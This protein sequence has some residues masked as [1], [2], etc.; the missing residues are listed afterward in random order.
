MRRQGEAPM[1]P[2]AGSA[3][4]PPHQL[5]RL[6]ST[7]PGLTD[8]ADALEHFFGT[9]LLFGSLAGQA[10][11]ARR[12]VSL[13]ERLATLPRTNL[14]VERP[15]TIR[16]NHHHVPFIEAETD[17]DLAV[18]LG[19][20]HAHL[21]LG[22]LE[23]MRRLGQG[24]VAA[25]IGAGGVAIDHLLRTLDI[26]R[27]VPAII[28]DMP[29]AT[30]AWVEAFLRGLN[31]H[32]M[33]VRPLPPEFDVLKLEPEPWNI[34]DVVTL[35]RLVS[36]DVNWII[37][38]QLLKF[39]NDA[40]WPQLWRKLL[41][42][43]SLSC[44]TS[45]TKNAA[46]DLPGVAFHP[47]SNSFVVGPSRTATGGALIA[48][49]PHLSMILPNAWLLAA[50]KS[51]SYHAA[52][53]MIPG[54]PF[55]ALGRNPWIA[56]GG[57]NLHAASSDFV[58]VP[59]EA[60]S[61]AT[62]RESALRV[63]W[64]H[65]RKIRIRETQWGPVIT[66]APRLSA[67]NRAL[68]LRW[69]GHRPSDEITAMLA[70]NRAR[71]WAE[72]RA[73]LDG[74]AVPGQNMTFAAA[75]GRIGRVMAARLPRRDAG[76]SDDIAVAPGR[77]D[78]WDAPMSSGALPQIADPPE[79]IITSANERPPQ[80]SPSVG[81][82]FAPRDR[83]QR[84]DQ[85]LAAADRLSV[86]AAAQIQRD[87]HWQSALAQC[88]QI[89]TWLDSAGVSHGKSQYH[90]V[91]DALTRWD[92]CYDEASSG[93]LVFEILFY[94]LV[95]RLVPRRHRAMYGAAWGARRLLWDD[96]VAADDERRQRGLHY[97]LKKV[98]R[99][100]GNDETWGSR[101][102]L[103]LGHPLA[104]LPVIGRTWRFADLPSGGTTDTLMK[105]AHALTNRRHSIRYGS[106]A[107]HISDCSDPDQNYFVLLGGQDG[108]WGST[109]FLDQLSLW[110]RG[111]YIVVPLRPQT[112]AL[113]FQHRTDLTP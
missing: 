2:A 20:V 17:E 72:F 58:A 12:A 36:A 33:R 109:T 51:P 5:A 98:A 7:L 83:K 14:P 107:R 78:G 35:G 13:V 64:G 42:V 65:S 3:P 50:C 62:E 95:R 91:I 99:A 15:I 48:S 23:L 102:R 63:R 21:R 9:A 92:G 34:A 41:A 69:M 6:W 108:W 111:A 54:L 93:A 38:L 61:A 110:R 81:L 49:D 1:V 19:I 45:E 73:A 86:E 79:A 74:F 16:W 101:H 59:A 87:V 40:D 68:A 100:I 25:M 10:R 88:R 27:A 103:R 84:L 106:I 26:G 67:N 105:T 11:R 31:H 97:A 113:T 24:R 85:L 55:V 96:V 70:I 47:G 32:L 29:P 71:D 75:S 39:R 56:W 66:D 46:A 77:S 94:H 60:L 30:R 28:A 112:A 44:W 53:L 8:L 76:P 90:P 43:D 18:A 22:Q 37:W 82:H 104:I 89:L 52:G 57:T 80:D 4:Q